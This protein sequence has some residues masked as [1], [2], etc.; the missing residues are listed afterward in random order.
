MSELNL[1]PVLKKTD[2]T[3]DFSACSKNKESAV[4]AEWFIF[5][6]E[7]VIIGWHVAQKTWEYSAIR[8]DKTLGLM[9]WNN[10]EGT[11]KVV[12]DIIKKAYN[13]HVV[14]K[15]LLGRNEDPQQELPV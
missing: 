14:E 12:N 9:V 6:Q 10:G 8:E 4:L 2:S 15:A 7:S 5:L 1:V 11:W 3:Y 13:D